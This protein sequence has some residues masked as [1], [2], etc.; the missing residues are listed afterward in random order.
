M[1]N[2]LKSNSTK[3][4]TMRCQAEMN[5]MLTVKTLRS[6]VTCGGDPPEGHRA[7]PNITQKSVL[8]LMRLPWNKAISSKTYIQLLETKLTK[9]PHILERKKRKKPTVVRSDSIRSNRYH[10][11]VQ[12]GRHCPF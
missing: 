7:E 2:E 3:N 4:R 1:T 6:R 11:R 12:K 9:Y 8:S 10:V 5:K